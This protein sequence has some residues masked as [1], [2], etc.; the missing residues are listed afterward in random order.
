[1]A[2]KIQTK[3]KGNN[4][5]IK[6]AKETKSNYQKEVEKE[7]ERLKEVEKKNRYYSAL[8]KG[9]KDTK[10]DINIDKNNSNN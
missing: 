5:T 3:K 4:K 6:K 10:E 8:S 2:R 7:M 9:P 1:M